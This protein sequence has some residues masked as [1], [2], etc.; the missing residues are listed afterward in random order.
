MI[1]KFDIKG[2]FFCEALIIAKVAL[3]FVILQ[4]LCLL[5][6]RNL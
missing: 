4:N 5:V 6:I 1:L 3:L 2:T